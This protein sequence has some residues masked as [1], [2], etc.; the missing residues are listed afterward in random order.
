[1][2]RALNFIN[3]TYPMPMKYVNKAIMGL[4]FLIVVSC[5][6]ANAQKQKATDINQLIQSRNFIFKAESV[7][8]SK[9][10]FRNVTSDYDLRVFGD[11]VI[12]YLPYFGEAYTAPMNPG[13]A[14]LQFTSIHFQYTAKPAKKGGWEITINPTDAGDVR[15]MYLNITSTGYATLN[16]TCNNRQ[17]IS[18]SGYIQ[19]RKWSKG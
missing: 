18:F 3:E 15:Q 17:P 1:M 7:T 16:V 13:D 5:F 19:P 9:G 4:S 6:G 11:S 14:G 10:G 8:P 12:S 2:V